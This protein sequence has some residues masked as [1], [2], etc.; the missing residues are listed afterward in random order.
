MM[1][2]VPP[3]RMSSGP[4]IHHEGTP[5]A[6]T[7]ERRRRRPRRERRLRARDGRQQMARGTCG[8]RSSTPRT[9]N[10]RIG[11]GLLRRASDHRHRRHRQA[12]CY[13]RTDVKS[14]RPVAPCCEQQ[15]PK[16]TD[17]NLTRR[18]RA[19]ERWTIVAWRC[20]CRARRPPGCGGTV[21]VARSMGAFLT[22]GINA[23]FVLPSRDGRA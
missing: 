14:S 7:S 12:R 3:C 13:R 6:C 1:T 8:C 20:S 11:R 21:R 2:A 15:V 9:R 19:D 18:L 5:A 23:P 4:G 17:M 10:V 16:F 22:S